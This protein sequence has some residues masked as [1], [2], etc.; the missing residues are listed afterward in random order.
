MGG[1]KI[2]NKKHDLLIDDYENQK[3]KH[4]EKIATKQLKNDEKFQRLKNI[5]ID[6][7]FLKNFDDDED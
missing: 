5:K 4:L 2:K 3:R 7:D 1:K 6:P